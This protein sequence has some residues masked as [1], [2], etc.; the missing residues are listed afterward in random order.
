MEFELFEE[1]AGIDASANAAVHWEAACEVLGRLV[2]KDA[3]QRWFRSSRLLGVE[4]NRAVIAVPNEIHQ[5][6]IETNYLPEL[7]SAVSES[8]AGVCGVRLVVDSNPAPEPVAASG[9]SPVF[10]SEPVAA[11][12]LST[13][14]TLEKRL[15]TA[16][17]NPQFTLDSFVVGANS[18]FAHA[19][20]EAVAKRKGL[21]YNPLFIHGGPGLGKTHL[22]HAIGNE[23]LRSVPASRVVYL[24]CEK[25][26][27]EFIDA[28]RK[29]DLERFR[30]RYRSVEVMLLDDVQFLGGKERSQEEFF[31]TFNTLLDGRCQV[32]LT[33]DRPASEIKN[34]EPRL[35]SRFECGLTV[36]LQA[37]V[38]ETRLAI[39]GKKRD[40]WKVK[41]DEGIIRFLAERIR[42]N[43]R[44]LE[45]ALMRVATFASLAS[46]QITE[47]RVEHLLRDLLRE[48]AGKQVTID[49]I[50]RVV[51]DH[52]DVRLADM[53]SR[54]RPASIA[55]PRQVA[56]YLS[57]TLTKGSLMEIGEAFGGRDHG[58][59]IHACKKISSQIEADAGVRD[60]LGAIEAT[61]RR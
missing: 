42:S 46:D 25:F 30:K 5:V 45:G 22:M 21:G 32:V 54:R 48:E 58:T 37:P 24:T 53:T 9:E 40:E 18:Q 2:S 4:D 8:I 16:G 19:A 12:S 34:L 29:G 20:C 38:F 10:P 17:V 14:I 43:V 6:W 61:L 57:R 55:F 59:V 41:V 60:A 11:V 31:H 15:K 51:A 44:R 13:E 49:A 26:T 7:A 50:Q 23:W 52:F 3:Y 33:S 56:M 27:N 35:I 36:E 28:V 39:L 1:D 47:E